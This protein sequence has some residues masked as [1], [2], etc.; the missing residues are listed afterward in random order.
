MWGPVHW[1]PWYLYLIY[2]YI[3]IPYMYIYIHLY[4]ISASTLKMLSINRKE[5]FLNPTKWKFE[6]PLFLSATN[7]YYRSLCPFMITTPTFVK[8]NWKSYFSALELNRDLRF[9]EDLY[10]EPPD[11]S[12]SFVCIYTAYIYIYIYI[13]SIYIY[14]Y[15][16]IYT[17][18]YSISLDLKN[19]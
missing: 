6:E 12:I 2:I 5:G 15:V 1:T 19:A 11:T 9:C 3:Y 8:K 17:Y 13:Y 10:M 7:G 16:H 14:M 4:I 18:I